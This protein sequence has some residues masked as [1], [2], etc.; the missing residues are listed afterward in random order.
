[1]IAVVNIEAVP[2]IIVTK[3]PVQAQVKSFV[4]NIKM[5]NDKIELIKM[6]L[7]KFTVNRHSLNKFVI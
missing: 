1:M 7:K 6:A 4:I 2:H 5:E 3:N